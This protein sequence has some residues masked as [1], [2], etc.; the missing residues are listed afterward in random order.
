MHA[1][2]AKDE[3]PFPSFF[4]TVWCTKQDTSMT[5]CLANCREGK[6]LSVFRPNF[7]H[8]STT[9]FRQ[10][11]NQFTLLENLVSLCLDK[12]SIHLWSNTISVIL[13]ALQ[14]LEFSVP[15]ICPKYPVH[16]GESRWIVPWL[17]VKQSM[18]IVMKI[19][20]SIDG[21]NSGKAPWEVITTVSFNS[22]QH[23]HTHPNPEGE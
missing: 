9:K 3:T 11:Q 5:D 17:G 6:A 13:V 19:R 16:V 15:L 2:K 12:S 7:H 21:K 4:Q 1:T 18:M 22:L 14:S 10:T 20:T 8:F 23:P